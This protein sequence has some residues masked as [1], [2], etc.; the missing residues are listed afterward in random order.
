MADEQVPDEP[1]SAQPPSEAAPPEEEDEITRIHDKYFYR[2]F[3][4]TSNAAGLLRPYL[5][6]AVAGS[7]RWATLTHWP[8]RF[9]SDD[10]RGR[11]ADLVFSAEREGTEEPVLVYALLEHQ[12]TPRYWMALRVLNYCLQ[13]WVAWQGASKNKKKTKLPL[14]VPLVFYQGGKRWSPELE[15]RELVEGAAAEWRWVPRFE[16][17]LIDQT[18]G[19]PEAVLGSAVARLTQIAMMA[20]VRGGDELVERTAVLMAEVSPAGEVGGAGAARGVRAGDA[21]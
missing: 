2:V 6:P 7:L 21:V 15:F 11:E 16:Y 20:R 4:D 13:I 5:P 10:W 8:G 12:S 14:I 3:S 17:L 9:V 19:G 1:P 18:K